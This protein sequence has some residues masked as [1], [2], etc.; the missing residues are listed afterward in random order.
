MVGAGTARDEG[1][2]PADVPLVLISRRGEVPQG[3]RDAGPGRVVMVV[4]ASAEHLGEAERTLGAEHVWVLGE[5]EVDVAA[6]RDRMAE[7][8]WREITCEGG[9]S[10]LGVLLG[11]GLID[12]VAATLVPRV[13]AGEHARMT[14]GRDVDVDLELVSLLEEDGTLLGRWRV[15][16]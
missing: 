13:L 12:E 1:Y 11:A 4:P 3:L 5:D 16:R 2:G 9:P 7:Q 15:R 8:G 10:T 14:A 6:L